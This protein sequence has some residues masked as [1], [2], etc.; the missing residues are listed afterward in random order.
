MTS[1]NKTRCRT[2]RS[3]I[4]SFRDQ[5]KVRRETKEA[6]RTA[7]PEAAIVPLAFKPKL[8]AIKSR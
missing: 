1:P 6:G 5:G 7:K 3:E 2:Y 4:C 8:A